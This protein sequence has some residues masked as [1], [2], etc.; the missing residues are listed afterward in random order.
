MCSYGKLV[1]IP[2]QSVNTFSILLVFLILV[3]SKTTEVKPGKER[4]KTKP[5][6]WLTVIASLTAKDSFTAICA[7]NWFYIFRPKPP[8]TW[9]ITQQ[10]KCIRTFNCQFPLKPAGKKKKK[11]MVFFC[12]PPPK[13][14]T[15]S[16]YIMWL[17]C[18]LLVQ[19]SVVSVHFGEGIAIKCF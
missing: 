13:T 19:Y 16:T 18:L 6:L 11:S 7:L 5:T 12:A 8:R 9:K 2:P 15:T 1:L 3:W 17:L 10:K 14:Q 4:G